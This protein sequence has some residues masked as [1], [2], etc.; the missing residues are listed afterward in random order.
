M[1]A[2]VAFELTVALE[3]SD[4]R[5]PSHLFVSSRRPPDELDTAA[6]I[7]DLPEGEFLDELQ[8]RYGGVP[9]VVRREPELLALLLPTLR[10]DVRALE[11]YAPL[12][13]RKVRCPV[14]VYGGLDDRRPRPEQLDGWRRWAEQEIRVRLFPGDHFYLAAQQELLTADLAARWA[15]A[16]SP[17]EPT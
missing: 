14:A 16:T 8:C 17:A 1:G 10:A 6:P 4:E 15:D 2:L 12:T 7:H 11:T 3:A 13:D 5:A 9:E